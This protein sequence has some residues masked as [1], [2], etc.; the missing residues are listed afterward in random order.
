MK[1]VAHIR[2]GTDQDVT[3]TEEEID[4]SL[5]R[6]VPLRVEDLQEAGHQAHLDHQADH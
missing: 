2:E 4:L 1:E 5:V 6:T 3:K